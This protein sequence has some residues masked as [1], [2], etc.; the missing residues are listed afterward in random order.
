VRGRLR[1]HSATAKQ[2]CSSSSFVARQMAHKTLFS[3]I[4][5]AWLRS[6]P[7]IGQPSNSASGFHEKESEP[8][9]SQRWSR[10]P[11]VTSGTDERIGGLGTRY[12]AFR[13]A[14][15]RSPSP[16]D[17]DGYILQLRL[18][19]SPSPHDSASIGDREC[20]APALGG[21]L[22]PP[23]SSIRGHMRNADIVSAALPAM[24]KLSRN[25]HKAKGQEINPC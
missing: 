6:Y 14:D 15:L 5:C 24:P 21:A 10:V 17:L 16:P 19:L 11:S 22:C 8:Q 18:R 13:D 9:H 3:F 2:Y 12:R 23:A 20:C 4:L 1:C 25:K 7:Q